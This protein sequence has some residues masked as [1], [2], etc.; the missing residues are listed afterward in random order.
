MYYFSCDIEFIVKKW[1][2]QE[3]FL[4]I[5]PNLIQIFFDGLLPTMFLN[6]KTTSKR[7]TNQLTKSSIHR[8]SEWKINHN[9]G[10]QRNKKQCYSITGEK[11]TQSSNNDIVN[12]D[13]N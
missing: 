12:S 4:K 10:Q 8:L 11:T 7:A 6:L 2:E 9:S 5:T 3:F 1:H 13:S